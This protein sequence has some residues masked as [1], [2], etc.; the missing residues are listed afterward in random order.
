MV[1]TTME[2]PHFLDSTQVT[3]HR[4]HI[5]PNQ[6]IQQSMM[7]ISV[8]FSKIISQEMK[9]KDKMFSEKDWQEVLPKKLCKHG[10]TLVK[11]KQADILTNISTKFG[12]NTM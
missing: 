11:N 4:L 6:E 9:R 7:N 3:I 8:M 5:Y 1:N 10:T 12:R 2:L